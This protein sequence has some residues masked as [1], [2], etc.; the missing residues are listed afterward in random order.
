M[1]G[2]TGP[3]VA[4]KCLSPTHRNDKMPF[5]GKPLL[6]DFL[7]DLRFDLAAV[8]LDVSGWITNRLDKYP[9]MC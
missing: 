2:A 9:I 8:Q 7:R 5:F 6:H 1:R 4:L 3:V